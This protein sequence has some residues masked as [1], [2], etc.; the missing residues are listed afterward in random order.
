MLLKCRLT[1]SRRNNQKT[2]CLAITV[3]PSLSLK[4][5]TWMILTLGPKTRECQN[6]M[7]SLCT[8]WAT[9]VGP[10]RRDSRRIENLTS[11]KC[12]PRSHLD[13]NK[14]HRL[15]GDS[16]SEFRLSR[17]LRPRKQGAC[18]A[19]KALVASKKINPWDK[20]PAPAR[21]S[22]TVRKNKIFNSSHNSHRKKVLALKNSWQMS[23][24]TVS[25]FTC[26]S[27]RKSTSVIL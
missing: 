8:M 19:K 18:S 16:P 1:Q 23:T 27:L 12:L 10:C 21:D 5:S 2:F 20:R 4:T 14:I 15:S 6:K 13:S 22:L 26:A 9:R 3:Q 11:S 24:L 25:R 7:R 17:P